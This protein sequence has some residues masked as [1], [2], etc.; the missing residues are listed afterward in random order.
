MDLLVLGGTQWLGRKVSEVALARGH[1]VVCLARGE[2]GPVADGA[3]LLAA[4][5][6]QPGAYDAASGRD[7]DAVVEVSWQPAFVREALAAVGPRA[8]HW[9][10]VS[11]ISAYAYGPGDPVDESAPLLPATD[12]DVVGREQYG[13]A[14]VACERLSREAVGDRLAVAR[15]GLI[16]GPGDHTD[17]SGAWVAR[18]ARD[19][20]GPLLVPSAPGLD[21]QE[22]DVRDLARWLV[23]VAERGVVGTFD[24]V[25]PPLSFEAWVE[26]S[27]AVGGHHG[28]VVHAPSDWLVAQGVEQWAGPG[29]LALWTASDLP[30]RAGDAAR[31]AG[32]EHRPTQELLRDVLAWE[33]AQGLDRER[34]AGLSRERERALLAALTE[35]QG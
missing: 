33:R 1:D 2:A 35:H 25:G 17:R 3:A 11:S 14:K 6:A 23:E 21:V 18:A 27:R 7:W 16:G 34:R 30:A 15:A 10:Y 20:E 5:R 29:S 26:A 19:P 24:V 13:G 12:L 8:A 4:D 9:A 28:P 32:L 31:R 22:V